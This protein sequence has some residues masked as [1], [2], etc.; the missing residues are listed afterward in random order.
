MLQ[1]FKAAFPNSI[2][3]VQKLNDGKRQIEFDRMI[4]QKL[5]IPV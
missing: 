5:I 4:V 1:S 2:L 3:I